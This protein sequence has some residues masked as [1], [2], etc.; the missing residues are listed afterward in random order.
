MPAVSPATELAVKA[1]VRQFYD[2]V[3]WRQ[4]GEGLYQNARY[5]DLRP[6]SREYLHRCHRR[7]SPL[8]AAPEGAY[9]LDAGS[10]PHPISGVP[11]VLREAS[12]T[13]CVW[14]SLDGRCSRPANG[15]AGMGCSSLGTSPTCR[16]G[17]G[18]SKALSSLH[19]VHHLPLPSSSAASAASCACCGQAA[20]RRVVYS[21]GRASP[22][23]RLSAPSG[24][25]PTACSPAAPAIGAGGTAEVGSRAG[26]LQAEELLGR[27]AAPYL[28]I[29]TTAG[30]STSLPTSRVRNPGLADGEHRLPAGA[31]PRPAAWGAVAAAAVPAGGTRPTVRAAGAVS[32]PDP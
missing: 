18:R 19:T 23:M 32:R 3:G 7:V 22:L 28:H 5:E 17:A 29:T 9:L 11:G 4:I 15:S 20:G 13:G 26:Q 6:V 1:Q 25:Q 10:G 14:T 16:S 31:H 30:S 8:S 12:A 2:S 21:L 27:P 24:R